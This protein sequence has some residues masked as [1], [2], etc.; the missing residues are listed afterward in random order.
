MS[1][2][3]DLVYSV[4]HDLEPILT[5]IRPFLA[6]AQW[7]FVILIIFN[8]FSNREHSR[9]FSFILDNVLVGY[10][11]ICG[12]IFAFYPHEKNIFNLIGLIIGII[13]VSSQIMMSIL[14]RKED[15]EKE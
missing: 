5:T 15:I 4:R 6:L 9:I 8:L 1:Y 11:F 3:I 12:I 2:L 14:L 10:A 13:F 7:V